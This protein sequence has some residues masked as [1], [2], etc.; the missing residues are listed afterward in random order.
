[1]TN[2]KTLKDSFYYKKYTDVL[3][4]ILFLVPELNNIKDL[5]NSYLLMPNFKDISYLSDCDILK[6]D[7]FYQ[8]FKDSFYYDINK[9]L[10]DLKF[11]AKL[12][13]KIKTNQAIKKTDKTRYKKINFSNLLSW[14]N[15]SKIY[16]K[17]IDYRENILTKMEG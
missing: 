17:V 10:Q 11:L 9:A 16:Y 5:K 12:N 1:M 8:N 14:C 3:N 2:I 13:A 6:K 15:G 7:I 4:N